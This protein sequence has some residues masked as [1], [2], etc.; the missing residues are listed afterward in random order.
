MELLIISYLEN[1]KAH[2]WG[3][4]P[5]VHFAQRGTDDTFG[6]GGV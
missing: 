1:N 5:A 6:D 3:R 2:N 4:V